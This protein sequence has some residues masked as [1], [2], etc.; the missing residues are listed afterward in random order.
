M[1]PPPA[2]PSVHPAHGV[3]GSS[4]RPRGRKTMGGA[5]PCPCVSLPRLW[6][7]GRGTEPPIRVGDRCPPPALYFPAVPR[8]LL[9]PDYPS[10]MPGLAW[11]ALQRKPRSF[12]RDAQRM[13][14]RLSPPL[15]AEGPLPDLDQGSW[16]VV[17]NHYSRPGFRAWWIAMA[18]SATLPR[19]VRW[20]ITSTLTFPDR[21]R[22]QTV[23]PASR[24]FLRHAAGLYDFV[25]MPPMPPR[26][27]EVAPRAQAVRRVLRA[28]SE[29]HALLGLAPE[30]GDMPGGV[31][32]GPPSGSGRFLWHL[33]QRGLRFLPV[34]AF[35]ADGRFCLRF[36]PPFDLPPSL[37]DPIE[38]SAAHIVMSAIAACLPERLRGSYD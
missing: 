3:A 31:L 25:A 20:V 23:T 2:S 19:E 8:R 21:L 33:A 24:R 5:H 17:V 37:P 22:A 38:E 4:L 16:L 14:Q 26:S 12:R 18:I 1:G 35:E 13:L 30:G 29:P 27:F 15:Q 11:L 28:A 9:P 32:A 7:D 6:I 34:G 10:T 36:G